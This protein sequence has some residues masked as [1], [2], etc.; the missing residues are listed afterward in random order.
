MQQGDPLGPVLFSVAIHSLASELV[1]AFNVWYLDD[2]TLGGSPQSIL[3]DFTTI[4][5]R[6]SS[7]GLSLN[8][9]KYEL[10]MASASSSH[11]VNELQSVAPGVCL[12]NSSEVTLL[13]SPITLDALPSS[14][15]PR[16]AL[17]RSLHHV[18]KLCLHIMP[19]TYYVIALPFLNS[20]VYCVLLHCGGF[21]GF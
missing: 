15:S 5:G 10:Y 9:S 13:G 19:F 14:L 3:T 17:F 7:S 21:L 12:L 20:F 4:L 8:L 18:L 2:G 1:S 6:S 16:S 11:F